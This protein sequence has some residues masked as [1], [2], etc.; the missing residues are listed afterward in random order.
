MVSAMTALGRRHQEA[1]LVEA[2]APPS[3]AVVSADEPSTVGRST[4][5]SRPAGRNQGSGRIVERLS[6][7]GRLGPPHGVTASG[8]TTSENSPRSATSSTA[9]AISGVQRTSPSPSATMTCRSIGGSDMHTFRIAH[10]GDTHYA[11]KYLDEVDRCMRFIIDQLRGHARR[12]R[13]SGR[14]ARSPTGAE[15]PRILKAIERISELA[16]RADPD[17]A[18]RIARRTPRTRRVPLG[19][20]TWPS[21]SL[22]SSVRF[23]WSA[24]DSSTSSI[25][26]RLAASCSRAC[27]R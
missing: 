6:F 15:Q 8:S 14:H 26:A 12:H 4:D 9:S 25:P 17:L 16:D 7:A 19:R 22:T 21:M 3:A 27:H 2:G 11:D 10:I 18:R 20:A 5:R 1:E 24:A 23:Y 13:H